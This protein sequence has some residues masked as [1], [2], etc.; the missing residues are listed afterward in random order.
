MRAFTTIHPLATFDCNPNFLF[1]S[2]CFGS[3][4]LF[5]VHTSHG[6]PVDLVIFVASICLHF[7]TT[8][9]CLSRESSA[10]CV[11]LFFHIVP[12]ISSVAFQYPRAW[13][14]LFRAS[15]PVYH[16]CCLYARYQ[17]YPL[18]PFHQLVWVGAA[19]LLTICISHVL[20]DCMFGGSRI[21]NKTN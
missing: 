17:S 6:W 7:G 16:A 1:G 20:S 19:R 8:D 12:G 2:H 15:I 4:N 13:K 11:G 10:P 18:F 3:Q 5:S 14:R 21:P 9:G